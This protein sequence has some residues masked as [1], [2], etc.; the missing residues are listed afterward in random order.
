VIVDKFPR[1]VEEPPVSLR[2]TGGSSTAEATTARTKTET[3]PGQ[4]RSAASEVKCAA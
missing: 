1:A 4:R 2:S 3:E